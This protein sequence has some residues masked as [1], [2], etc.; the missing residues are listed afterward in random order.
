MV[1]SAAQEI[2]KKH[3]LLSSMY[4]CFFVMYPIASVW[5]IAASAMDGM[6]GGTS[7]MI[8]GKTSTVFIFWK[9]QRSS[10]FICLFCLNLKTNENIQSSFI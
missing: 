4:C 8:L 6:F 5:Y 7:S 2:S 10:H 9:F 1:V 3:D